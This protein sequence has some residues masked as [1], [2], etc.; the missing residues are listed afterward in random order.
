MDAS[1][2]Q[3]LRLRA[4]KSFTGAVLPLDELTLLVGRN[5][6]GKSNALDGLWA[7]S[8]LAHGDDVR[9]ALGGSADGLDVRGGVA[10]CAP[11]GT[12]SFWLGCTVQ[13]GQVRTRLDVRV[14][15][16]PWPHIVA[17]KLQEHDDVLLETDPPQAGSGD[18]VAAW[19]NRKQGPNP[20]LSFMASRLLTAQ[21]PTRV[22][23]TTRPGQ[24]VHLAAA[25]VLAALRSVFLLDPVPPLMR[26]YVPSRDVVL[27]RDADNLSATVGALLDDP[28]ARPVLVDALRELSEQKVVDVA[29]I[30]SDLDDVMLTVHERFAGQDHQVPARMMSDGTLR[31]LA[32]VAA[33][34]QAPALDAH[35]SSASFDQAVGQTTVV[36]EELENGL[37]ASQAKL[38]LRL[39]REQV[40]KRRVR[41]LATSHSSA[42]LDALSGDEHHSIVVCQR[43]TDGTSGLH[44]L[45][46]LPNY[47]DVVTGGGL[48][49]AAED[50]RLRL[51]HREQRAPSDVLA[52]ILGGTG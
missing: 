31:F 39:V 48:G 7:L 27:R 13:T 36:I 12:G 23:A 33:L 28:A 17:E 2:L 29:T 43:G 34:L 32:I 45:T 44:R 10:G 35:A 50:D 16:E 22:P 14:Q 30:R 4:F 1:Y 20:K 3:E 24:R 15:I 9:D 47:V 5:G 26:R 21:V 51:S 46:E 42:L 41:L 11:L 19:N 25:R 52:A 40:K 8:R 38:L 18:I 49:R 6:S 37:H